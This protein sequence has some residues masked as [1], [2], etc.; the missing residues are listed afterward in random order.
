MSP[1]DWNTAIIEEFR[2]NGGEVKGHQFPGSPL[3]LL[4]T[5]GAKS[6]KEHVNPAAYIMEGDQYVIIA[7]M[8]GAPKHPDWY[9][10]LLAN[11]TVTV[12]AGTER[13]Q[14]TAKVVDEPERTRLYNKMAAV[15]PSFTEYQKKTTRVIPV[16]ALTRIQ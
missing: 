5:T 7:S 4:H 3:L 9:Y 16:I 15:R 1:N 14:A 12:E 11:P 8:A 13:F 6:G 10:N 2:A